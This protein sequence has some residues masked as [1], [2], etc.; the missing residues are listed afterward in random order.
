[1]TT[2]TTA[3]RSTLT[4]GSTLSTPANTTILTVNEYNNIQRKLADLLIAVIIIG[5][6][7]GL[8]VIGVFVASF[9]L[10]NA[11]PKIVRF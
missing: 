6:F 11:I 1:M 7:T 3:T 5:I 8:A 9:C 10:K 2:A 4:T